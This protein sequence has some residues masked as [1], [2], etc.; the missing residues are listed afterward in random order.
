MWIAWIMQ[1]GSGELVFLNS[2]GHRFKLRSSVTAQ[3][4]VYIQNKPGIVESGGV[5]LGRYIL[6]CSDVVVDRITTP[7]AGD[8]RTR[9]RFF[10]SARSH[11]RVIDAAWFSSNG[12]CNYIGEW[13]T[14]P[15][16][17]PSPSL[18]GILDWR[19]RFLLDRIDSEVLYFV[20]LGTQQ[21]NVWQVNR[22]AL[23]IEKL[24]PLGKNITSG[25][26]ELPQG[27]G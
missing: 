25:Q 4:Y 17:D 7:V 26:S 18:V 13:H 8:R 12:T 15:E 16:P 10:R 23:R 14:H 1:P 27:Q 19:K 2:A 20:V 9:I 22:G 5:L 11:Q 3:M 24:Q 21:L 6:N